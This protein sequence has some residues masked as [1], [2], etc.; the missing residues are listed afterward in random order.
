MQHGAWYRNN[1]L[2]RRRKGR[3]GWSGK[4]ILPRIPARYDHK[5][6]SKQTKKQTKSKFPRE[7]GKQNIQANRTIG[8][9][10]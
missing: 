8:K 1:L 10:V 2:S 3:C 4:G 6:K 5:N 9:T 7:H